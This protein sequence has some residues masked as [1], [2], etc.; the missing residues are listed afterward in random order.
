MVIALLLVL[1][2]ETDRG[3]IRYEISKYRVFK[4]VGIIRKNQST[5]PFQKIER[6]DINQSAIG[7]LVN[8]GTVRVDTGEDHFLLEGVRDPKKIDQIIFEEGIK[9]Q[10]GR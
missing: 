4:T 1:K 10:S 2:V 3:K 9:K 6:T 7:R 8:I 5:I